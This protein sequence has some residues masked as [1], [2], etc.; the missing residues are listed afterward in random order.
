VRKRKEK[1]MHSPSEGEKCALSK[2]WL[3]P[4]KH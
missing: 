4:T 2:C 1:W 3:P